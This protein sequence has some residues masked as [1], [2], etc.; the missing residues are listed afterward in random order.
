MQ[1]LAFGPWRARSSALG[2]STL[3]RQTMTERLYY[4]DSFLYD[5]DAEVL[6]LASDS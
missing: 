3:Y 5:F 4:H 6:D 2:F 1:T